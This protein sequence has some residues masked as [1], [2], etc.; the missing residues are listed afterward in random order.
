VNRGPC[1]LLNVG[2]EG[3]GLPYAR[4][5]AAPLPTR[6]IERGAVFGLL[7]VLAIPITH[8]ID[9]NCTALVAA[10]P[11]IKVDIP[12]GALYVARCRHDADDPALR[13]PTTVA[14]RLQFR[15]EPGSRVLFD[16]WQQ[17]NGSLEIVPAFGNTLEGVWIETRGDV[18]VKSTT[19][20]ALSFVAESVRNSSLVIGSGTTLRGTE[21]AASFVVFD[22][23]NPTIAAGADCEVLA[24]GY[25]AAA[26]T[27]PGNGLGGL[28]LINVTLSAQRGS[29]VTALG[30]TP[31]R[32]DFVAA[33][34]ASGRWL[35]V[36]DRVFTAQRCVVLGKGRNAVASVGIATLAFSGTTTI[37]VSRTRWAA[38]ASDVRAYGTGAG[39][40]S[41]G[42][43]V[44]SFSSL[45]DSQ[46]GIS[47]VGSTIT[48]SFSNVTAQG[49]H[50]VTSVGIASHSEGRCNISV[51]VKET[52]VA[53]NSS[54]INATGTRSGVASVGIAADNY[55]PFNGGSGCGINTT[56]TTFSVTSSNVSASAGCC[57][58]ASVGIASHCNGGVNHS[59]DARRTP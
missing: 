3:C 10:A 30:T 27:S 43:V 47:V 33:L 50:A 36:V 52:T 8:T 34:G 48:S 16:G 4:R 38:E 55:C 58:V 32:S 45:A 54:T 9:L 13:I 51:K 40:V 37:S 5:D 15:C 59:I 42:I 11:E 19:G 35:T 12:S 20:H 22:I 18:L 28:A 41:V 39:V 17:K 31:G 24:Q 25:A 1:S 44:A 21:T 2:E 23:R 56:E 26:V 53:A 49:G 46:N 7:A 14:L 29:T 6:R 57:A